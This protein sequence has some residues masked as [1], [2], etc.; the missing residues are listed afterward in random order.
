MSESAAVITYI[1]FGLTILSATG[2]TWSLW[3]NHNNKEEYSRRLDGIRGVVDSNK[4]ALKFLKEHI[5]K[6]EAKLPATDDIEARAGAVLE[7]SNS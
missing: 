1:G 3:S 4:T 2:L 7:P 6:L 5:L